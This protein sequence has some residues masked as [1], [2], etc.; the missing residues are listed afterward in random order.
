MTR[1]FILLISLLLTAV[2][3]AESAELKSGVFE[4]P[5]MAPDFVLQSSNGGEF[6]LSQTRGK[7]VILGFG[8]SRCTN[9]CPIT[10]ANLAQVRKKLAASGK[11]DDMQVVYVTVDPQHDTPEWLRIYLTGFHPSFIG[12]TGAEAQLSAVRK[13]YGIIAGKA[14]GKTGQ[15]EVHH[16]SYIYLIDRAGQLRALVPFGKSPDDIVHD[17]KIL[18]QT[19]PVAKKAG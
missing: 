11:A 14:A 8:F 19:N 2:A 15:D 10:L 18:L 12:L 7:V 3:T 9:V 4:P 1:V 17:V 16:S 5:R 13:E 6:S